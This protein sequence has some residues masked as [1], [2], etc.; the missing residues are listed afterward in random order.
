M[1]FFQR[2][3]Y[4]AAG[5]SEIPLFPLVS[6]QYVAV[7]QYTNWTVE[8]SVRDGYK[9][10][11]WVYR[12][13]NVIT[14]AVSSVTWKVV[15][16]NNQPV[17]NHAVTA[18][19]ARPNP[20]MPPSRVWKT[21]WT[22]LQLAGNAY[23]NRIASGN[24][25]LALYPVLPDKI[26]P[27]PNSDPGPL[28]KQYNFVNSFGGIGG[29][30][31]FDAEEIIHLLF[32][33]PSN[34]LMG[35]G[36]LQAASKQVDINAAQNDWNKNA[37]D[38]RAVPPG[39]FMF[40]GQIMTPEQFEVVRQ[41]IKE[42][43]SGTKRARAPLVLAGNSPKYQQM[44]M[45]PVEM[46]FIE[47]K[48]MGREEICAAFGVPPVMVGI[49]DKA[50]YNNSKEMETAFWTHTLIPQLDDL[51]DAFT[52]AFETE[53]QGNKLIY[54]L[55]GVKIIQEAMTEKLAAAQKAWI[56]GV[57]LTELNRRHE[58]GYDLDGVPGAD[59]PRQQGPISTTGDIP[60]TQDAQQQEADPKNSVKKKSSDVL[61]DLQWRRIDRKRVAW[62]DPVSKRFAGLF[63]QQHEAVLAEI[64]ANGVHDARIAGII[65]QGTDKWE[66]ELGDVYR[67]VITDFANTVKPVKGKRD[68]ARVEESVRQFV[69]HNT[70]KKIRQIQ[71]TTVQ[72]VNDVIQ[73]AREASAN[74]SE[75]QQQLTDMGMTQ[76]EYFQS[77]VEDG[78]NEKYDQFSASRA[79][80]IA[81]TEVG[82]ASGF[83]QLE[84]GK[85][86]GFEQKVWMTSRDGHVR[87]SHQELDDDTTDMDDVFPNGLAFP[88][89]PNA[90][91]PGEVIN[92]RC[93]LSFQDIQE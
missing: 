72:Q 12:C 67:D 28:I 54:D 18:L 76:E 87:D 47:S 74:I 78:L 22:H 73:R 40:D 70:G 15:D 42:Q 24:R 89:D 25:T 1:N 5:Q 10:D 52:W 3:L 85:I 56:M 45:T 55:S 2:L 9:A 66:S 75:I 16:K 80:T 69:R 77:Q 50:T 11:I 20:D 81:R 90:T 65:H 44:G 84:S 6:T 14:H 93:A 21:I 68:R 64:K 29:K 82:S 51:A 23:L 48:R 33:D 79:L 38:N 17:D 88:C 58:L 26:A 59:Q 37:M 19:M 53:L 46:D 8:K 31:A 7:P 61:K 39:A 60:A 83:G 91:D 62:W 4:R 86:A 27:V 63:D 57:P 49:L 92:C 35:I 32:P 13:I 34:L 30:K 41:Q 36:P 71:D 43:I